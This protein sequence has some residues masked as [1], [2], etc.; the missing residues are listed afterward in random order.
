VWVWP[1]PAPGGS[2]GHIHQDAKSA[3]AWK[4]Q[5]ADGRIAGSRCDGF[6]QTSFPSEMPPFAPAR[7]IY[8]C[9]KVPVWPY[10][11]RWCS[12]DRRNTDLGFARRRQE[13]AVVHSKRPAAPTRH[14]GGPS[15]RCLLNKV[16]SQ[17][18]APFPSLREGSTSFGE[19]ASV[20]TE[21]YCVDGRRIRQAPSVTKLA[22]S[23]EPASAR[24]LP[25]A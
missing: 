4:Q 15:A 20:C 16:E 9:A 21:Y 23:A 1:S 13:T 5:Q 7:R 18:S 12:E 22:D 11:G 2:C 17:W 10:A 3:Q 14:G 24:A 19:F 8:L 25:L 6:M